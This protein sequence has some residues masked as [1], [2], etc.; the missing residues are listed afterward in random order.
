MSDD[1]TLLR[2]QWPN[3]MADM[4]AIDRA[5]DNYYAYMEAEMFLFDFFASL[6]YLPNGRQA[7]ASMMQRKQPA[8]KPPRWVKLNA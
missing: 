1:G 3:F 2:E 7:L 4:D 6:E 8:A 5:T